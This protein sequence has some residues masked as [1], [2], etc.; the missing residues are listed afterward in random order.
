MK[1]RVLLITSLAN[2]ALLFTVIN[3]PIEG[4][5]FSYAA[6][7]NG[8]PDCNTLR[9]TMPSISDI[10]TSEYDGSS[11]HS[12]STAYS[13][14][15]TVTAVYTQGGYYHAF[16]Q[17]NPNGYSSAALCL[18]KIGATSTSSP[19]AVG[20]FVTVTGTL[21][22]YNGMY[23]MIMTDAG[24]SFVR[25]TSITSYPVI[26]ETYPESVYLATKGTEQWDT[27]A[28]KGNIRVSLSDLTLNSVTNAYA[29]VSFKN[30]TDKFKL[31]Y[32]SIG[33]TTAIKNVLQTAYNGGCKIDV[34]GYLSV[35]DRSSAEMQVLL[36]YA[37][38][39]TTKEAGEIP[40]TSVDFSLS[41]TTLGIG[42]T[43]YGNAHVSPSNATNQN[44]IW[45]SSDTSVATVNSNGEILGISD[46]SATI[47]VKSA[48]NESISNSMGIRVYD[49]SHYQIESI[50]TDSEEYNLETGESLVIDFAVTPSSISK[51]PLTVMLGDNGS[52]IVNIDGMD[53][54]SITLFGLSQGTTS[55]IFVYSFGSVYYE[56][57]VSISV[58]GSSIVPDLTDVI[59]FSSINPGSYSSNFGSAYYGSNNY[60]YAFYR[61]NRSN[62]VWNLYPSAN[63]STASTYS[64][65]GSFSNESANY[66][67]KSM[68][69]TYSGS[70]TLRYGETKDCT[71]SSVLSS[72]STLDTV[73]VNTNN[74]FFFY[75]EADRNETL[76]LSSIKFTYDR[77]TTYDSSIVHR[78]RI[79]TRIPA[80][81]YEGELVD[82]VSYVDVP[83]DVTIKDN[84]YTV[85]QTK[86]Y[87]YYS[88][89][90]VNEHQS[91]LNLNEIALTDPVDIANYYI[92]FKCAPANYIAKNTVNAV[93]STLG[94]KDNVSSLFGSNA[95]YVSQYNRTDGYAVGL[96]YYGTPIYLEFDFDTNGSYT[97]SNRD[98]GRVVL[99]T[100]GWT[101]DGYGSGIP[102]ATF[103]DDHYVTFREY[104]NY[105]GWN[106]PFDSINNGSYTQTRTNYTYSSTNTLSA[107]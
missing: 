11:N 62:S 77:N 54:N 76:K 50:T 45:E 48:Y 106:L 78:N 17:N 42:E 64:T 39:I 21:T 84:C 38:D 79:N 15:G 104:N 97:L 83:V 22:Y 2:L 23:E 90:F 56:K 49:Y 74:A 65:P 96:P 88:Y 107:A 19:L 24:N 35:S 94:T 101:G 43:I 3:M 81:T 99:W 46:G 33:E 5:D 47:I 73:S 63:L 57:T 52:D 14:W 27:N 44:V 16:I 61:V 4:N 7:S 40:V 59:N 93:G 85:N 95:R 86:R 67:I 26:S 31:Y 89:E 12:T 80:T 36:R 70:G 87:I 100:T 60:K 6:S 69:I 71:S 9:N 105:G 37:D 51:D 25:E 58:T 66:A 103:T 29:Y 30:S 75:L 53:D 8:S 98:V 102:V 32:S 10:L 18:Y 41:S 20:D 55:L 28:K 72:S 13:T 91:E 68:D 1:K 82:G 92:A 34:T